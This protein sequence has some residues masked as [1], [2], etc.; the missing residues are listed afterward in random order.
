MNIAIDFDET[1]FPT[2]G[3]IINIYNNRHDTNISI[4]QI[5][6][7]SLR[8]CLDTEIANEMLSMFGQKETYENLQPYKYATEIV[9]KLINQ[10][11]GIFIATATEVNNLKWKE[12]LLQK[13]FPFI[14]KHNLIRIHKK[15]LLKV[16]V[17]IDDY[18]NNL[19]NS[20]AEK[21]CFD[22]A[23]NRDQ[24]IEHQYNIHRAYSW[25]DILNIIKNLETENRK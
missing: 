8:E 12:D 11:H 10:G 21:I 5:T 20:E 23:W 15:D 7:Y 22:C 6:T 9:Q 4:E 1:L 25:D 24:Q 16:D 13:Y 14:P 18:L 3:N 19:M 17:I 2:L